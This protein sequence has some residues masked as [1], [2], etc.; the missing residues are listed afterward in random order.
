ML[1]IKNLDITYHDFIQVVSG[2]SLK[3]TAGS[4]VA[5][6]GSNGAG[7]ST[8]LK[9]VSGILEIEDEEDESTSCVIRASIRPER[10]IRAPDLQE[11]ARTKK[12]LIKIE[13]GMFFG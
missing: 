11:R 7:K 6:L 10:K 13:F 3:V 1:E 4:T 8:V 12:K 2:V 5:L 9:A